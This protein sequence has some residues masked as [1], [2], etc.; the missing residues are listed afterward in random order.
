MFKS[1]FR[2]NWLATLKLNLKLLPWN[3]ARRLP[4]V[5][6]GPLRIEI[7]EEARIVLP[8][9]AR[10]GTITLGSR[11][12]TY[13]AEAGKA[14]FSIFGTWNVNGP[15]RIGIDSC[16]YIHRGATL[17]TGSEIFFARDSQIECAESVTIG[18]NVLAGEIYLCDS[19]GHEVEHG[20][21]VQPM[22]RPIS[23]GDGCYFGFRTMVL[24][25]AKIPPHCVIGS[26]AVCTR[27][28]VEAL[29]EG[30][31][32]LAGVPAEVKACDVTP[33]CHV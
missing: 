9:E 20:K 18:D 5:V 28:F 22:T 31:L 13:K 3:Q 21:E 11:H 8:N 12:E 26:G 2:T 16:L 1:L 17:T 33:D 25:G 19:A 15:V 30:H 32:L 6:E 29:P 4:I 14:Q 7:G 27:D 10:R 24:R 23:I